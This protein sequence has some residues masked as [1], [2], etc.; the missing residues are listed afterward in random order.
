MHWSMRVGG[1]EAGNRVRK[2]VGTME[3]VLQDMISLNQLSLFQE[4]RKCIVGEPQDKP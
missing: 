1:G 2:A 4:Y 3:K